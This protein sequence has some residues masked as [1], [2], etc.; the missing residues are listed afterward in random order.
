MRILTK[1]LDTDMDLTKLHSQV[2]FIFV[3]F[4]LSFH[5]N[6]SMDIGD[7]NFSNIHRGVF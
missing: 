1:K 3:A 2:V 5:P 6:A 7:K 4:H